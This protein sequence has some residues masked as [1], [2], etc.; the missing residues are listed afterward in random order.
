[1]LRLFVRRLLGLYW[2]LFIMLLALVCLRESF[3]DL[4]GWCLAR[5]KELMG[6]WVPFLWAWIQVLILIISYVFR[7]IAAIASNGC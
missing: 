3:F 7:H 5:D 1:L 6:R 2:L 4:T